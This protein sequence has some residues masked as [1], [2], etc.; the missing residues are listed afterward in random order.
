LLRLRGQLGA[1]RRQLDEL[2]VRDRQKSAQLT[3]TAPRG[4][5]EERYVFIGGEVSFPNRYILTNALTVLSAIQSASG[6]TVFG[7]RTKVRLIRNNETLATLDL[8]EIENGTV[9]DPIL[10]HNDQVIVPR[11][12]KRR[13]R[14]RLHQRRA[15]RAL[16]KEQL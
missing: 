15:K 14:G 5:V 9:V 4:R 1:L 16:A 10:Q 3:N 11:Q 13:S 6:L 12:S 2:A 8:G 7:D